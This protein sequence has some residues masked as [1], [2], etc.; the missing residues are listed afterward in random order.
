MA[1]TCRRLGRGQPTPA[2]LWASGNAG[3]SWQQLHTT[4]PA[5]HATIYAQAD[6]AAYVGQDPVV[7]GTVDG[8]LA[9]WLG[10]PAAKSTGS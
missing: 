9:I 5:F 1:L 8:R 3:N 10:T 4:A 6:E 2:G 7:A